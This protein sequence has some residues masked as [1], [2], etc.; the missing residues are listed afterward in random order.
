MKG[1]ERRFCRQREAHKLNIWW[2]NA[3]TF[4]ARP[5]AH[6]LEREKHPAVPAGKGRAAAG[7]FPW[8]VPSKKPPRSLQD[9]RLTKRCSHGSDKHRPNKKP[10]KKGMPLLCCSESVPRKG[11]V[12]KE[13][14]TRELTETGDYFKII[15]GCNCAG[16]W[17]AAH[18]AQGS[19]C[20]RGKGAVLL[21][22]TTKGTALTSLLEAG[23]KQ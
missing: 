20:A 23:S 10:H 11:D 13:N 18:L 8:L 9:I 7:T 14:G 1:T 15:Q 4:P 5:A 3:P 12:Q 21:A 16:G 2:P 19:P 22:G 17:R 6:S